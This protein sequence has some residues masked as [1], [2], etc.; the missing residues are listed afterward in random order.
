MSAAILKLVLVS[1]AEIH[2][3]ALVELVHI[4]KLKN[5]IQYVSVIVVSLEIQCKFAHS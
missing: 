2:V 5:I 1:D 4:A 3:L